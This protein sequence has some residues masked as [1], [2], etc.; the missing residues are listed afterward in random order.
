[1]LEYK[2]TKNQRMLF[3]AVWDVLSNIHE[4]GGD[5]SKR[6]KQERNK[7]GG[8]GNP[9]KIEELLNEHSIVVL[10]FSGQKA[11][12]AFGSQLGVSR[13]EKAVSLFVSSIEVCRT[14]LFVVRTARWILKRR[15]LSGKWCCP[16]SVQLSRVYLIA[17]L[18]PILVTLVKKPFKLS[19]LWISW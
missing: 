2:N 15:H 17:Q 1:M 19:W 16:T 7:A 9:N 3:F 13:D 12:Q 18:G 6:W 4:N 10:V 8:S 14:V 11:I 5:W